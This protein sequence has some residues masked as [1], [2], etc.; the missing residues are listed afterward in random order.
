MGGKGVDRLRTDAVETDGEL[1]DVIVV[2]GAGVDDGE[3]I[4]RAYRGDASAIVADF[5]GAVRDLDFDLV[6]V[7][8]MNSSIPLSTIS[9]NSM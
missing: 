5:H 1:E 6:S 3:R 2:L 4:P 8:M 9:F 7:S